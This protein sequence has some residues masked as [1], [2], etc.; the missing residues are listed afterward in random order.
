MIRPAADSS[1]DDRQTTLSTVLNQQCNTN[2]KMILICVSND[3]TDRYSMI[4]RVCSVQNAVPLMFSIDVVNVLLSPKNSTVTI[5]PSIAIT[6]TN[7]THHNL[8]KINEI[9]AFDF[10][11]VGCDDCTSF[12]RFCWFPSTLAGLFRIWNDFS[13]LL[14]R[15]R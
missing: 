5:F 11:F 9:C 15:N 6:R 12:F 4:K 13:M 2:P 3:Q 10:K 8:V 7:I 1:T 14:Q